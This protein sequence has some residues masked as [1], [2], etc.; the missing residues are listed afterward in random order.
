M[1]L[2]KFCSYL[3]LGKV[4]FVISFISRAYF[5]K[6]EEIKK[7]VTDWVHF[8]PSGF[9]KYSVM[10]LKADIRCISL[11]FPTGWGAFPCSQ[12]SFQNFLINLSTARGTYFLNNLKWQLLNTLKVQVLLIIP[13]LCLSEWCAS[14]NKAQN[15]IQAGLK[16]ASKPFIMHMLKL[17]QSFKQTYF[18][19][20]VSITSHVIKGWPNFC[21]WLATLVFGNKTVS[22]V[23]CMK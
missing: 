2:Y 10:N 16:Q 12:I 19:W 6:G 1:Y 20:T 5:Y 9:N 4:L 22:A 11:S 13:E 15:S 8:S 14:G 7:G 23:S 17:V 21:H 3:T 18:F